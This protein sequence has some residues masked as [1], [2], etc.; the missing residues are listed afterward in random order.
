MVGRG[1]AEGDGS[2][3]GDVR[4]EELVSLLDRDGPADGADDVG[5]LEDDDVLGD[6]VEV[7]GVTS[8]GPP[9]GTCGGPGLLASAWLANASRTGTSRQTPSTPSRRIITMPASLPDHREYWV[10]AE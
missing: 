3:A 6:A 2:G 7:P 8:N 9:A 4:A 5:R 10:R 1:V